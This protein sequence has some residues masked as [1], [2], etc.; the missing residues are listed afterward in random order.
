MVIATLVREDGLKMV[1]IGL[2][3]TN[4]EMLKRGK[5]ILRQIMVG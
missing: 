5:Q 4:I 3:E 2:S 1:V